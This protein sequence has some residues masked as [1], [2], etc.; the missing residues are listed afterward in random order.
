MLSNILTKI[1]ETIHELYKSDIASEFDTSKVKVEYSKFGNVDLSTNISFIIA[2]LLKK[3]SQDIASE[4][5]LILQDKIQF[6]Q[7]VATNG[8]INFKLNDLGLTQILNGQIDAIKKS[9]VPQIKMARLWLNLV[10]QIHTRP[11]T[12]G[13]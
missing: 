9:I 13:I 8:Y 12:L 7:V 3:S 6:A 11:F 2:P 5:S 1:I 10:N 4:L